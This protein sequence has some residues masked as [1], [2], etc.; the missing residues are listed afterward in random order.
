MCGVDRAAFISVS[1]RFD[2]GRLHTAA[3]GPAVVDPVRCTRFWRQWAT[4]ELQ[5]ESP[6]SSFV[7][8]SERGGP[9]STAGFAKL[10]ERAEVVA[11]FDFKAH[12]Q[13]LRHTCGFAPANAGHDTRALQ[14]YLGHRNIQHTVR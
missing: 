13:M 14:A 7:F 11:S 10:I 9:F 5:R 8:A 3:A 12:L 4:Q 6:A 2:R 1:A